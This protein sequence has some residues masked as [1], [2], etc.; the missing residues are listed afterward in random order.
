MR[1]GAVA[2]LCSVV[3]LLSIQASP[4]SGQ[5]LCPRCFDFAQFGYCGIRQLQDLPPGSRVRDSTYRPAANTLRTVLH[6]SDIVYEHDLYGR[7]LRTF[8]YTGLRNNEFLGIADYRATEVSTLDETGTIAT[9]ELYNDLTN[10]GP[11]TESPLTMENIIPVTAGIVPVSGLA[12]SQKYGHFYFHGRQG[13]YSGPVAMDER[14]SVI[15]VPQDQANSELEGN[16]ASLVASDRS[17]YLYML[18]ADQQAIY[19]VPLEGFNVGNRPERMTSLI[20]IPGPYSEDGILPPPRLPDELNTDQSFVN[21]RRKAH[22]R[23]LLQGTRLNMQ[24][25]GMGLRAD[26]SLLTVVAE[27]GRILYWCSDADER[28]ADEAGDFEFNNRSDYDDIDDYDDTGEGELGELDEAR[29]S[30]FQ[31]S[32]DDTRNAP[33]ASLPGQSPQSA[34][35]F[36]SALIGQLPSFVVSQNNGD[37]EV[38][39]TGNAPPAEVEEESPPPASSNPF[40]FV[41][42]PQFGNGFP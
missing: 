9:G 15:T 18:H 39:G 28:R 35:D 40:A 30:L 21:G 13:A 23:S 42:N 16:V 25:A 7:L 4:A 6:D 2:T 24:P 11:G 14:A 1:S 41:E 19:R 38:L 3:V 36:L 33:V 22:R 12:Y 29:E 8:Q 34:L 32:T 31:G 5:N 26:G 17:G 27:D 37:F 10:Y 20:D